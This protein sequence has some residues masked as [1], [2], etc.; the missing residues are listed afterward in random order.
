MLEWGRVE[1]PGLLYSWTR[2]HVAM[3]PSVVKALPYHIGVIAFPDC[4]G[5]RLVAWLDHRANTTPVIGAKCA[6]DWIVADTGQPVPVF[7]T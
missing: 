4:D 2:V 3:H 5:V 1:G 7:R 6:L